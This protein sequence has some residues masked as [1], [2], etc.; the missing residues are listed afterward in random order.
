M[1]QAR[2][3]GGFVAI[4]LLASASA[5][6]ADEPKDANGKSAEKRAE[7]AWNT[8]RG[9][10]QNNAEGNG[11]RPFLDPALQFSMMPILDSSD[12][13]TKGQGMAW[14][15]QH[16][17]Q[18]LNKIDQRP[19]HPPIPAFFPIAMSGRVIFRTYNGVYCLATR[20]DPTQSPPVKAFDLQWLYEC[21][22]SL[23]SM[24]STGGRRNQ[25]DS[26]WNSFYMTQGPFGIFFE[27]GLNGSLSHDGSSVYFVDDMGLAPH[28][29]MQAKDGNNGVPTYGRDFDDMV[30]CNK[31]LAVSLESGKLVWKAGGRRK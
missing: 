29:Q 2:F 9:N 31:L 25:I 22:N 20:D 3:G 28:P 14:I 8:A 13:E 7:P 15:D 19:N 12:Q 26:Q 6:R 10:P 11:G 16:L 30:R 1:S 5:V 27:N 24:V 23:Y 18:Y 4:L 21:D 17:K